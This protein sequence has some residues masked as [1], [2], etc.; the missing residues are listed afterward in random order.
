[1]SSSSAEDPNEINGP[2]VFSCNNCKTI[3]GDS[4]SFVSSDEQQKTL[5]LIASS[6]IERSKNV[7]TSKSGYDVGS[8]YFTFACLYCKLQLGKYYLTTSKDLDL[9]REKFTFQCDNIATYELGKAKYG[10]QLEKDTLS[11]GGEDDAN[12]SKLSSDWPSSR[13]TDIDS[14]VLKVNYSNKFFSQLN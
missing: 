13:R 4:Y 14:E 6:N 3:V 1:M 2:L 9:V 5:T 8:T 12:I 7:F 11:F 10:K